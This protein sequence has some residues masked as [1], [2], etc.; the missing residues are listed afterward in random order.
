MKRI[1]V[2]V[3]MGLMAAASAVGAQ[4]EGEAGSRKARASQPVTQTQ[5]AELLVKA[6]GLVSYLPNA[7]TSQQMF[8]V[9]MQNGISPA[10]G[11]LMGDEAVVTKADLARVL[12]QALRAVDQVENPDDPQS[13]IDTLK[14]MGISL[15]RL[16]E[17]IQSVEMLPDA[18][19][20]DVTLY[21]TDPLIKGEQLARDNIDVQYSVDLNVLARIFPEIEMIRG[22]FR[23]IS[24][25]PF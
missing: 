1:L 5:L 9:L 19:G 14:A 8:D 10:G 20:Q 2:F 4:K 18:L 11:W 17:T 24:P 13:W 15:D 6:L 23:P 12:V 3:L 16:S 21:S 22:E 25:T 7:P